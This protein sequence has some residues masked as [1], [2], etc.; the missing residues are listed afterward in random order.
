MTRDPEL[1]YTGQGYP[2][3]NFTLAVE[4]NFTNRNGVKEVDFI[5]IKAWQK[6]AEICTSNLSKGRLVA[7]TGRLQ[8]RKNTKGDRTYINPEVIA[9]EVKFLDWPADKDSTQKSDN[10]TEAGLNQSSQN[11]AHNGYNNEMPNEEDMKIDVPF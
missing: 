10:Q 2:V 4:R 8:I 6:L 7:V 11:T 5:D 9:G 1:N 3:A